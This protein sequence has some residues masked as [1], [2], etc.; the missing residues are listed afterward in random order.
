MLMRI[1]LIQRRFFGRTLGHAAPLRTQLALKQVIR[2]QLRLL[3]LRK[4]CDDLSQIFFFH[5]LAPTHLRGLL[6][7]RSSR[8]IQRFFTNQCRVLCFCGKS[9][10]HE[11]SR[12]CKRHQEQKVKYFAVCHHHLPYTVC[13]IISE[14]SCGSMLPPVSTA[15]VLPAGSSSAWN[16]AAAVVTAPLG[17]AR[18]RA[19]NSSRRIARRISSSVTV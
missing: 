17:S 2:C 1:L 7:I 12:P 5:R 18:T 8:A 6:R 14:K 16:M 11:S 19:E 10:G 4:L 13:R 9:A 3:R 15:T